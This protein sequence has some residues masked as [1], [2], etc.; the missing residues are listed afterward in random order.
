MVKRKKTSTVLAWVI[1]VDGLLSLLIGGAL[2]LYRSPAAPASQTAPNVNVGPNLSAEKPDLQMI[3]NH[4]A[5]P[6]QPKYINIPAIGVQQVRIFSMGLLPNS[7]IKTPSNI[8]DAGWYDASAKPGKP[9]VMF[10]FGHVS[11]NEN[12][13]I[14]RDLK[15]LNTGNEVLVVGGDDKTYRYEVTGQASYAADQVDMSKILSPA[16]GA[17]ELNLMTCDGKYDAKTQTF[18]KRLVVFTRLV[19]S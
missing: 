12:N 11:S 16:S 3:T 1:V 19:Q 2:L 15:K 9:G 7:A 18:S 17:A 8:Y 4:T 13:G 14:F 6:D 10:V 5:P